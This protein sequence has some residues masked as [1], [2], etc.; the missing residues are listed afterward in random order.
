MKPL[1]EKSAAKTTANSAGRSGRDAFEKLAIVLKRKK[2]ASD[3]SSAEETGEHQSS[4]EPSVQTVEE[5]GVVK[6]IIVTCSCGAVTEIDCQ[7]D[8]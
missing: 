5:D 8:A 2:S 4:C 7:Y 1:V 3:E 6:R